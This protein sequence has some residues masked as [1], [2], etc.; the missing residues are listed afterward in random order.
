MK[1][2]IIV[3]KQSRINPSNE[4]KQYEI[5]IEE[6]RTDGTTYDSL[7]ITR[8]ETYVMRRL[9]LSEYHVLTV[10]EEPI[11]ET[12]TEINIE[13]FE[14]D[15]YIYLVDMVG[16]KFYA[17][18]LIKNDFNDIYA[19][20]NEMN[21][22]IN[23]TAQ[24]IELT[25]NQKL[26][27]YSTTEQMN[28]IIQLLS[29]N[30]L[31]EVS[32]KVGN[33][34]IISSINMS[35][36][37]I[38]I[39]ADKIDI[40]GKAVHFKT[41]ISVTIG[42]F[43]ENDSDKVRKYIMNEISLTSEELSKYDINGD[44]NISSLDW[45]Y[46]RH[47][48]NNGGYLTF[49]GT[50]E[51]NPYSKDKSIALY[52]SRLGKY[53]SIISLVY[54]YFNHLYTNGIDVEGQLWVKNDYGEMH[55]QEGID[56]G[57]FEL[58]I[59]GDIR[60][61]KNIECEK[62]TQTSLKSKKKNIKKLNVNALDLIKNSDICLYN[63]KGEEAKSKKH[64]GLVIGEGYNCPDEVISEDGQGVEQYS[65]TS[66]AWKAIQELIQENNN[67]KQRIEKLEVQNGNN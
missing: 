11:K 28:A 5:D 60:G 15:N 38:Q 61:I 22:A 48:I 29:Q 34:N 8:E 33:D 65:M 32:K 16:N 40:D 50:Y 35:P 55:T 13:L 1:Y 58:W 53:Q 4:R 36:E 24:S 52:D 42:P 21:A 56:S 41:N 18:Y 43:T 6:L 31:L 23:S 9:K 44:G 10:L 25:V 3:D 67:L 45:T 63:L 20:K 30:I 17:E 66:L 7:V 62:V 27:G 57:N 19:T 59:D 37:E 14:G 51:I 49:E 2:T 39:N 47:A 12:L 54:N 64:I 46:I 26:E